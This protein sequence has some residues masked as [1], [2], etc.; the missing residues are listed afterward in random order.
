M[1][2]W[3][4]CLA[5]A[6][7][8]TRPTTIPAPGSARLAVAVRPGTISAKHLGCAADRRGY[9]SSPAR[10]SA[11]MARTQQ[12]RV[13][14]QRSTL[15]GRGPPRCGLHLA[16]AL[17]RNRLDAALGGVAIS[18]NSQ[19]NW[20]TWVSSGT[21]QERIGSHSPRGPADAPRVIITLLLGMERQAHRREP[22]TLYIAVPLVLF[23]LLYAAPGAAAIARGWVPP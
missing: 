19:F 16:D 5:W 20:R 2:I 12:P 6:R 1:P 15:L 11:G 13:T 4:K 18:L 8:N 22:V 23:A 17:H 21:Q 7:F 3:A 14:R 10:N 9:G